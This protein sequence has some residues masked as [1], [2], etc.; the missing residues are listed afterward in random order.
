MHDELKDAFKL[1]VMKKLTPLGYAENSGTIFA[2]ELSPGVLGCVGYLTSN[3]QSAVKAFVG[4]RFEHV[5][6]IYD[7][8]MKPFLVGPKS[9]S[10]YFPSVFRDIYDLKQERSTNPNFRSTESSYL[11]IEYR[12]VSDAAG[13]FLID[14]QQYG[15]PYV[16]FNSSLSN[17]AATIIERRGGGIGTVAYRLPIMYW[18]LGQAHAAK[19]YLV[20]T[21]A[22]RYPI[23]P[24]EKFATLLAARIDAGAAPLPPN[25]H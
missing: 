21:A 24:Y 23:G 7:E 1:A 10:R 14:V 25:V 17:A 9:T 4:V 16:E 13:R 11:A 6:K 8:L 2:R 12:T 15:I 20:N 18:I 5:E 22:Q 3:A 19:E